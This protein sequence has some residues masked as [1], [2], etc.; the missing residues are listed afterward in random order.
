MPIPS[1]STVSPLPMF[2]TSESCVA[3]IVIH[4][5]PNAAVADTST[6]GATASQFSTRINPPAPAGG[7]TSRAGNG[8]C[9]ST[10][11]R[12]FS[13]KAATSTGGTY[14]REDTPLQNRT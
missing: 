8:N 1:Q 14:T 13:R 3:V 12:A 5:G 6:A 7:D 9:R 2:H 11:R 10:L 4:T